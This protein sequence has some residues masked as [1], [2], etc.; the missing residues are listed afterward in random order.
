MDTEP[1]CNRTVRDD[2]LMQRDAG[3]QYGV[4]A[5]ALC[6]TTEQLSRN[7]QAVVKRSR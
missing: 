3:Y 4:T 6:H 7:L 2:F 5:H 1:L